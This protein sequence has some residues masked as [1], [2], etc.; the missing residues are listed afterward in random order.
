MKTKQKSLVYAVWKG[1]ETGVF[2]DWYDCRESVMGYWGSQFIGFP[3]KEE[4]EEAFKGTFVDAM[5]RRWGTKNKSNENP[6]N[7]IAPA[8]CASSSEY[9]HYGELLTRI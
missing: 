2:T 3:S 5:V 6:I 1:R 8:Y 9:F 4:A 7:G